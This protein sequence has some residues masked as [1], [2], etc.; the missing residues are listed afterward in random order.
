MANDID[1]KLRIQNF[2]GYNIDGYFTPTTGGPK[3]FVERR[4]TL[5]IFTLRRRQNIF[6]ETTGQFLQ[7]IELEFETANTEA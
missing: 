6:C 3:P 1:R 4:P 5:F 7:M 2:Q